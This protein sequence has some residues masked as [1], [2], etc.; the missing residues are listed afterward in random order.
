MYFDPAPGITTKNLIKLIHNP[1][2]RCKWDKDVELAK[3]FELTSDCK[4]IL[5]L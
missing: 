3:N 5:F 1:I 2:E 4:V